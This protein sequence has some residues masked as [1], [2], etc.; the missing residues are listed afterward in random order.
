MRVKFCLL[1]APVSLAR[2]TTWRPM[3]RVT[4][5]FCTPLVCLRVLW[6]VQT[7]ARYSQSTDMC[8]FSGRV[9]MPLSW[10][11]QTLEAHGCIRVNLAL[12]LSV[13]SSYSSKS[14]S[15]FASLIFI[16][17]SYYMNKNVPGNVSIGFHLKLHET[18]K[19]NIKENKRWIGQ[20]RPHWHLD[21][22]DG[23][24]TE[25]ETA[26]NS[27]LPKKCWT[28][29]DREGILPKFQPDSMV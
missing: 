4:P 24:E 26:A 17:S 6:P 15:V 9:A 5:E 19:Q 28:C 25:G 2:M 12:W 20:D 29:R 27:H 11:R 13:Q 8:R 3:R 14:C 16:A 18:F 10:L 1:C 23:K 22:V 7:C 21:S